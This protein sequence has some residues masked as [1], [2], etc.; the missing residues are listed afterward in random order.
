MIANLL[1]VR[2]FSPAAL[3]KRPQCSFPRLK[4]IY[5]FILLQISSTTNQDSNRCH[6]G[7]R[8]I[9]SLAL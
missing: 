5:F 9:T 7:Y 4:E 6:S 1:A 2:G 3:W 8:G